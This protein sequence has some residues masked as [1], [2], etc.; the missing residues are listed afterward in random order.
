VW[1]RRDDDCFRVP[2]P[3]LLA[4]RTVSRSARGRNRVGVRAAGV[5]RALYDRAAAAHLRVMGDYISK[6]TERVRSWHRTRNP[7]SSQATPV[8]FTGMLR[9][10]T[11]SPQTCSFSVSAGSLDGHWG[12]SSGLSVTTQISRERTTSHA[13]APTLQIR[14]EKQRPRS[15]S[16]ARPV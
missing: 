5:E 12:V 9:S 6:A 3:N 11:I 16:G 13:V 10:R 1:S 14:P 7:S 2:L 15:V 8:V 4:S